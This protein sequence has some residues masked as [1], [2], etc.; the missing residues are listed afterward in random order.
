MTLNINIPA[1]LDGRLRRAAD[2]RGIDPA[3]LARQL[4]EEHVP[5]P[6]AGRNTLPLFGGWQPAPRETSPDRFRS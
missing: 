4:I 3:E 6:D 5:Q 2:D 1:E